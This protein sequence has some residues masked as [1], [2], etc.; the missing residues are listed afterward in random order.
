MAQ[1]AVSLRL[2]SEAEPLIAEL[3]RYPDHYQSGMIRHFVRRLGL[4]PGERQASLQFIESCV[5]AMV[6]T[7]TEIDRFFFDWR[8]GDVRHPDAYTGEA[9]NPVRELIP[10]F[11]PAGTR[12]HPSW[13]DDAPCSMQIA[14]VETIWSA[15]AERD[16]WAPL[17][18]KVAAIRRMGEAH[19]PGGG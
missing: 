17:Y 12:D 18:A 1:L 9:W 7:G 8:C 10:S 11:T 6:E 5:H 4:V 3:E 16:D 19:A 14:V 2:L 13:S 15:I